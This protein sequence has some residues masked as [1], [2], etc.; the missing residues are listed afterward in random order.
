MAT[1]L[2]LSPLLAAMALG[3]TARH[4]LGSVGERVILPMERVASGPLREIMDPHIVAAGPEEELDLDAS[5]KCANTVP[6]E[7]ISRP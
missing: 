7:S 6:R 4:L 1:D 5:A 2:S 3:F